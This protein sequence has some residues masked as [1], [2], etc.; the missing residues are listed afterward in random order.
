MK[1]ILQF[2]SSQ[3]LLTSTAVWAN[4]ADDYSFKKQDLTFHVNC[5][6]WRHF[7]RNVKLCFL[8]TIRKYSKCRLLK[9]FPRVLSVKFN[10]LC[11]D[12]FPTCF[13]ICFE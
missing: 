10:I 7:A 3:N 9:I 5:L 8:G 6:H 4:S 11:V 1:Q 2:N 12:S 13:I